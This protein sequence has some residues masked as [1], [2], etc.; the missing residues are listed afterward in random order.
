MFCATVHWLWRVCLSLMQLT[1]NHCQVLPHQDNWLTVLPQW[2]QHLSLP[3]HSPSRNASMVWAESKEHD[4]IEQASTYTHTYTC[5]HACT[6]AHTHI[7]ACTHMDA[8]THTHTHTHTHTCT[9]VLNQ[10]KKT[11][12]DYLLLLHYDTV[13]TLTL[14]K[15]II[16]CFA[17]L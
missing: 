10:T 13:V 11:N 6:H 4:C 2:T 17:K 12:W 15:V 8:C 14:A 7:H 5:M 3:Q 9:E 16:T 1:V